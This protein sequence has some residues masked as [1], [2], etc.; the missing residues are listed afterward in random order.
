M[1][2]KEWLEDQIHFDIEPIHN[3][4]LAFDLFNWHLGI[5]HGP[6][7]IEV[8]IGPFSVTKQYDY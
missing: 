5:F 8:C 4:F 1:S 3:W 7:S 2:F 6:N